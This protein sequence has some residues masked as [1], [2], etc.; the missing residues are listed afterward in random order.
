MVVGPAGHGVRQVVGHSIGVGRRV[1][2]Q[3]GHRRPDVVL[4]DKGGQGFG[5]L[6]GQGFGGG[7]RGLGVDDGLVGRGQ[8]VLGGQNR[9]GQSLRVDVAAVG[10]LGGGRRG[11][12]LVERGPSRVKRGPR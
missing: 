6:G 2:A 12:G 3:V 11:P 4:G 7:H 5:D 10:R 8:G 9:G 1:E